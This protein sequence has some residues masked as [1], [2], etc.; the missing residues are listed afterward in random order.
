MLKFITYIKYVFNLGLVNFLLQQRKHCKF[1][2]SG[3]D[4]RKKLI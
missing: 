2:C 4:H 1:Y 3:K